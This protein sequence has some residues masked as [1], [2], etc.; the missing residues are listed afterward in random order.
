[1]RPRCIQR[2]YRVESLDFAA[3]HGTDT[4]EQYA[5][6]LLSQ[7]TFGA[8]KSELDA[9]VGSMSFPGSSPLVGDNAAAAA[10]AATVAAW[11]DSQIAKPPTLLRAHYR[12]R[13]NPRVDAKND[14][15]W[16]GTTRGEVRVRAHRPIHPSIPIMIDA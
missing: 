2:A 12:R 13:T 3:E 10:A 11:V 5:A 9:M 6:R 16:L 8:T 4:A 14:G 1:M 15:S 7:A